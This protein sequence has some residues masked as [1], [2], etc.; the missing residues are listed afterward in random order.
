MAHELDMSNNRANMAYAGQMPWHGLGQPLTEDADLDTWV[1]EAGMNWQL[2][3]EPVRYMVGDE[4]MTMKDRNVLYRDDTGAGLGV[5]SNDYR[6]VQPK[7]VMEF[8]RDLISDQGFKM[9]TAGC[10]Y[11]GRKF[12]ALARCGRTIKIANVDDVSPYL[13]LASSC[14]GSMSTVVHP[15]SVRVVCQNTLRMSI[16]ASGKHAKLKVSH[17]A[18]FDASVVKSELGLVSDLWEQF[19]DQAEMMARFKID[20]DHAIQLVADELKANDEERSSEELLAG[21]LALRRIINLYDGAGMGAQLKSSANTAWGLM[22]AVTQFCDHEA[23]AV[24]GDLSRSFER[25]HLTDR[26]SF[27]VRVANSL[28]KLAA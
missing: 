15:T 19:A 12:W 4:L 17:L 3:R 8:F 10:L 25:A 13:L 26:A 24:K 9:E 11:G 2:V 23:G 21:S 28:L 5:V 22:N 6:T 14:D 18:Q 1:R 27:K 16:G 20:R 7:D